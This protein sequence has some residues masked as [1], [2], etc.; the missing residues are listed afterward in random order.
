MFLAKLAGIRAQEFPEWDHLRK[1]QKIRDCV[2]HA[3]GHVSQMSARDEKS[4]REL[5]SQT[6]GFSIDDDGRIAVTK[7]FCEGQLAA[8][9]TLFKRLFLCVGWNP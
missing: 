9:Q 2:V 7:P 5:V 3:Y 4:L 8:L 6:E 1:L